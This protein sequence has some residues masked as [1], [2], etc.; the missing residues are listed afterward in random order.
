MYEAICFNC[1]Y[2][3]IPDLSVYDEYP[4]ISTYI[5]EGKYVNQE[6]KTQ[7]VEYNHR[8]FFCLSIMKTIPVSVQPWIYGDGSYWRAKQQYDM[9]YTTQEV[10]N[11]SV[12]SGYYSKFLDAYY[13][14]EN[15]EEISVIS[16]EH[17]NTFLFL[18]NNMTHEITLLPA[19]WASVSENLWDRDNWEFYEEEIV[20]KEHELPVN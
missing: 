15:L 18:A 16:N 10:E 17:K 12:A 1:I 11:K 5:T 8:N 6:Y 4:S 2:V 3:W 7:N 9:N 20:L 14:M 13:V 19:R